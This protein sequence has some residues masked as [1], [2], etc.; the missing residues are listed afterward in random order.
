[1]DVSGEIFPQRVEVSS[2]STPRYETN[3]AGYGHN[4]L[5][6]GENIIFNR[7]MK[8][9]SI[10]VEGNSVW[11][12]L[13]TKGFLNRLVQTHETQMHQLTEMKEH[14]GIMF[15]RI[16]F[17]SDSLF[18]IRY[19]LE[20]LIDDQIRDT[21]LKTQMLI[22]KPGECIALQVSEEEHLLRIKTHRMEVRVHKNLL[23]LLAYD[24]EGNL[25]WE[26]ARSDLFTS[27]IFDIS[28]VQ[29]Q[30]KE[31]FFESFYIEGQE[32]IFGLGERFD[33]VNRKGASVDF[34]NKDAIGTSN[35]RTYINV[36]F[37]L[38]TK[39]YGVFLNSTGRTEWEIA[40]L[41]AF[42]LGFSTESTQL[43]YF[44]IYGPNPSEI[45]AQYCEL[46][47]YPALP[48]VW[49]FGLW[50]S[51]NSYSSWDVV[52]EVA[53]GLREKDIPA[54]V[55]HLDTAWF[56]EDWNCDLRFSRERFPDPGI[57]M[58]ELRNQGFRVSLWQYNYIPPRNNNIN[59]VEATEKGYFAKFHDGRPFS[60]AG[61]EVPGA[62]L[63][64]LV[65]DFSNPEA[66]RW[67]AEQIKELIRLGAATIKT[68]FGE[69]IP[70]N[71]SYQNIDGSQFHNYYSLVY[72][73]VVA[74]AIREVSGE[75]VVWARSGTAGSQRYPIHWGGDSQ[76]SWS[77]LEGTLRAALSMGLSGFPFF[78]H[79]IGGFIGRPSPELYIRWAQFGLFS[80]H[81]RCHGL[82]NDNSREP[83][84]FGEE[85]ESIFRDY[86]KLRYRLL[87][88]LYTQAI[89]S[90]K[91]GK[92][93]VRALLIDYPEDRNVHHIQDQYLFGD[94]FL[95]API[96][97]PMEK[98]KKRCLYLPEGKWY[99][100]WTKQPKDSLGEWIETEVTLGIMP[101][102]VKAGSMIP[103]GNDRC[104]T[105]NEIGVISRVEFYGSLD[106][107]L[108]YD[109]GFIQFAA[110]QKGD[111]VQLSGLI[112]Q[113]VVEVIL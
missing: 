68:D 106:Q 5:K 12:E 44:I 39:G 46:T 43:D 109:D 56:H 79:D 100:Y 65:I 113:P 101:L 4:V 35:R 11:L 91:T 28:I 20:N 45:L 49:S 77:G 63:D 10:R 110:K 53:K 57:H 18:R 90:T 69:G 105:N 111:A 38:S 29:H 30:G 70:E 37:L 108:G 81:A 14:T 23:H 59:F 64:D 73:A 82:G 93:M 83:W 54:D 95:V 67:Y 47:G 102:Y 55:L 72:N 8:V 94:S 27:D 84:T 66:C 25:F 74:E 112:D 89:K 52:H 103:Y 86:A 41:E 99:D 31:V 19:G 1:M 40:T 76:C 107:E 13:E 88:Y 104:S 6:Q 62:W 48:P 87:P 58:N 80:S 7:A 85:A 32:E 97:K 78:S 3:G 34:W 71:A 51:R 17:W 33:H 50:M 2:G 9:S 15:A 98:T 36:P 24:S 92:P 26:Q 42:T 60:Y 96:L 16:D 22:G 61:T 75:T 21:P